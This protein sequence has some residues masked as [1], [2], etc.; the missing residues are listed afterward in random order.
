MVV[1]GNKKLILSIDAN[2]KAFW[3]SKISP[4]M[5]ED[6]QRFEETNVFEPVF[7]P[8]YLCSSL[9]I[10]VNLNFKTLSQVF[11]REHLRNNSLTCEAQT[12]PPGVE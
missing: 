3:K 1:Q 11:S 5:N 7:L 10:L 9:F 4:G 12:R 8:K 2:K 6:Q